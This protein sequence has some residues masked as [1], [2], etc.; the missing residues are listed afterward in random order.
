MDHP[1]NSLC[2]GHSIIV[3]VNIVIIVIIIIIIT[4][5]LLFFFTFSNC[6]PGSGLFSQNCP[7]TV[8]KDKCRCD[9]NIELIVKP[10]SEKC[11]DQFGSKCSL[12]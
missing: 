3:I 5:T 10:R 8:Q 11:V 6:Q 1:S 7:K 12:F 9:N 2:F 4:Y